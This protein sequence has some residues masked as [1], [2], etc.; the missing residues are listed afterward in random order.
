MGKVEA[1][2]RHASIAS[3]E[4]TTEDSSHVGDS[5]WPPKSR[6]TESEEKTVAVIS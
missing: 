3:G 6:D 2:L 5:R 4:A 1:D